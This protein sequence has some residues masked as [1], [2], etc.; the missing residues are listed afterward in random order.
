MNKET[1]KKILPVNTIVHLIKY[2]GFSY[3]QGVFTSAIIK[4]LSKEKAVLI[5]APCGYGDST[6]QFAKLKN[7]TVYG[8]DIDPGVIEKAKKISRPNLFFDIADIR[9][10]AKKH[11][12]VKYFCIINSLFLLPEPD[13]ILEAIRINLSDDGKL[14]IVAPN[15]NSVHF[16]R[17]QKDNPDVNKLILDINQLQRYFSSRGWFVDKTV[18]LAYTRS[19]KRKD[20]KLL[21]I[22]SPVYLHFLNV[23]QS[24]FKLGKPNSYLFV[25][26]KKRRINSIYN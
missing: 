8:Y 7:L 12:D 15:I 1:L 21:S 24:F 4:L 14:F 22:L 2:R 20:A 10:I 23:F 3:P 6:W 11:T 25:L 9:D 16:K 5:D 18:K 26:Q 13:K 19:Y 17:F